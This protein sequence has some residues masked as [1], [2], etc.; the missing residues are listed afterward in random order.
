MNCD[1]EVPRE[2]LRKS[3]VGGCGQVRSR[4]TRNS[5]KKEWIVI[6]GGG[7][8]RSGNTMNS[9]KKQ[10]FRKES[11]EWCFKGSVMVA[12]NNNRHFT[13]HLGLFVIPE[14]LTKG[15]YLSVAMVTECANSHARRTHYQGI[16]QPHLGASYHA[17]HRSERDEIDFT[18]S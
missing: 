3:S 6:D 18:H 13:G 4:S 12:K 1:L 14:I 8:V 10:V 15:F 2:G 7:K 16:A 5:Y 17:M 11:S 9:Y